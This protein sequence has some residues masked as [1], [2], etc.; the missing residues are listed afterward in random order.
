MTFADLA[1]RLASILQSIGFADL[2]DIAIIAFIVYQ[3]L[4][5]LKK[6]RAFQIR[7]GLALFFAV[8]VVAITF[9]LKTVTFLIDNLLQVGF[10]A[11]LVIFQPELRRAVEQVLSGMSLSLS[12]FR[13]K[14][15]EDLEVDRLRK[16]IIA[17]CDGIERMSEKQTGAL[18]VMENFTRLENIK[19]TGTAINSDIS[20]ELIGTIF[21]DG[22]PLHDGA[23]IV[24][25]GRITHAACVL[26]LSDNLEISKDMGTRH[27]AALGIS[28]I[29]DVIALVVSEETG[30]ISYAKNGVM[31]RNLDRQSLYETLDKEF[32]QPILSAQDKNS[33]SRFLRRKDN[34]QQQ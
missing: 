20:P 31:R 15:A 8:Y 11:L 12:V 16:S 19:R 14:T 23:V 25:N 13:K 6:T 34:E 28:E 1:G 33:Y 21:Y 30:T 7:T 24:H 2:V 26:P 27:R 5:L 3:V 18:I 4:I 32:V 22:S 29:S 9:N 10:I 17:I